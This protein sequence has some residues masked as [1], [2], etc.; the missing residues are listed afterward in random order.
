MVQCIF[1]LLNSQE[2]EDNT[3]NGVARSPKAGA[4]PQ[5][6]TYAAWESQQALGEW[7]AL[8]LLVSADWD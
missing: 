7:T 6:S 5:K 3:G 2:A 1:L 8:G 4:W